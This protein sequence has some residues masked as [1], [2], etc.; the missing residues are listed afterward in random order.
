MAHARAAASSPR[1][2]RRMRRSAHT[3]KPSFSQKCSAVALV[4][5]FPVQE[6]ASSWATTS[7]RER[8]PAS[9]VGVRKVMRGFSMPP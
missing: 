6:W 7:T 1:M 5:R 4:T 8:S 3:V 9:R 2:A